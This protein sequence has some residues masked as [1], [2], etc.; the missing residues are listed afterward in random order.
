MDELAYGFLSQPRGE[1]GVELADVVLGAGRLD[2]GE[3]A[4]GSVAEFEAM[5]LRRRRRAGAACR[6][7]SGRPVLLDLFSERRVG[8]G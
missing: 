6:R 7:P 3:D 5:V 4:G 8:G 2:A 1:G